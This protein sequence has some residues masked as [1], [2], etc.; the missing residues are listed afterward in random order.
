MLNRPNT[1]SGILNKAE[2][3]AKGVLAVNAERIDKDATWPE[4][5]LR[6]LMAE[7]FGGLVIPKQYGGRGQ[8]LLMLARGGETLSKECPSTGICFGMHCV[9]SSVM[10]A[11]ANEIQKEFFLSPI[12]EGKHLTTLSLS[13]EDG[14]PLGGRRFLVRLADG[15]ELAGVLDDEGKAELYIDEDAK[16]IFPDADNPRKA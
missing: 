15:S 14:K 10:S 1:A 11:N 3:I 8:G 12:C 9:A 4:K 16:V 5:G 13:D 2:E 6:T 7:G